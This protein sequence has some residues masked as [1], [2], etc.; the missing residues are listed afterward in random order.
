MCLYHFFQDNH[1]SRLEKV[2]AEK[3]NIA[4]QL[5]HVRE[6]TDKKRENITK[7]AAQALSLR[8]KGSEYTLSSQISDSRTAYAL[9]LYA[10]ISNVTWDYEVPAGKIGGCIGNDQERAYKHFSIDTRS[11][12]SFEVANNLWDLIGEGFEPIEVK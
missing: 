9:S 2:V 11:K 4:G 12:T 1:S 7:M 3:E 5:E 6:T 10:K 8:E